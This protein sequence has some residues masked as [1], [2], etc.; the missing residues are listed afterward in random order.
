M[1]KKIIITIIAVILVSVIVLIVVGRVRGKSEKEP[2]RIEVVRRGPFVVRLR[3]TGNLEPL[4]MV[5]VRSN[6]EGEIKELYVDDGVAVVK[7]QK[8][9][10]ID[11]KQIREELN[12]ASANYNAA[13]A[14]MDRA[15][16]NTS[17]SS[18]KLESDIQLSKNS[19]RSTESNLEGAKARGVQQRSQARISIANMES[20]LE[21]DRIALKQIDLALE[22][23][24]S[25]EKSAK[26]SVD[27][28]KSELD[29]KKELYA[30]KFVSLQDVENA[31]LAYSSAQ[32][33]HELTLKSIQSQ[34]ENRESQDKSIENWDMKI[35]AEKDDLITLEESIAEQI[36]QAEIQID[37]SKERLALLEKSKDGEKQ[38]SE[39]AKASAN[40][41]LMRAESVL[42]RA[43]ERLGWTT[44]IAPMAG[45]VV[46]CSVEEGEIITS[47]RAAWS[48][49][50]PVMVIAD[51]SKMVAKTYVHEVDIGKIKL[52]QKA[53]INIRSYPD[54][55]FI[56]EVREISPS[57]QGMD[58][59][60]KFEVIVMVIKAS[61][62][63]R[64]GM[65]AD[66]DIIFDERD[67]VLQLPIEAVTPKETIQIKTGIKKAVASNLLGQKI[68]LTLASYPDLKFAG[69]VI[70]IAPARPGFSTS[71]VTIIM[72]GSPKELQPDTSRTANIK[73]SDGTEIPNVEARI[74]S[75]K[76]YF[77]KF[78]KEG[79]AGSEEEDKM[80]EV[81]ERTQNNI[82]IFEGLKEG[83]KVRVVPPGEEEEEKK[84]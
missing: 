44:L 15:E 3:E 30:K 40:A 67:N 11:E 1:K 46:R 56:G 33:Q 16:Q 29:R 72:D 23:A 41:N 75:E 38:I 68:D 78:I 52:G 69:K 6:V 74:G 64:P 81:G 27:N 5:E 12:Q 7:G 53:E 19:L 8:L 84:K 49:G 45:K 70:D 60:I 4:T 65:T 26:A 57:G 59:I 54:D 80:I 20:L 39:L 36:K 79:E 73:L 14:E 35:K 71:E 58:N 77:V 10:K 63:L 17:L 37:Q 9:L 13:K 76:E 22:Q 55:K 83:D 62:P 43:K 50:A 34:K 47:G 31:Q 25:T 24:E 21:Q 28:A 82:E 18:D 51:L 42:N 2:D 66:V 61:K 48:Q 32:S